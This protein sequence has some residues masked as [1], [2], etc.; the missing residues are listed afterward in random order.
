MN[1][2]EIFPFLIDLSNHNEREWFA[3]HKSEY[4]RTRKIFESFVEK[5]IEK[6]GQFDEE[7]KGVNAKDCIFRIY[8]DTRFSG[9]KTPYKAYYSAYIAS[10]GGRKS[11]RGGYYIHVQPGESMIAGGVWCPEPNVLKALRKSVYE[12]VDEFSEIMNNPEFSAHYKELI[13]DK[14]KN[15]P[16][17]FP[18]DWEHGDWLKPKNYCVD[19]LVGDDLFF[20]DNALDEVARLMQLV[21]PFN[22]FF[23]FTLDEIVSER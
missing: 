6:I 23:N 5:L 21:Q 11:A 7:V 19:T 10:A 14:L 20:Q 16:A 15:V 9:D 22:R 13:G 4:E 3:E 17:G 12:N 1:L 8:R 2:K 18:K